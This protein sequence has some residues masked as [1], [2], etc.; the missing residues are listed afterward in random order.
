MSRTLSDLQDIFD[1]FKEE[2]RQAEL[3]TGS[4]RVS[5]ANVLAGK[6]RYLEASCEELESLL[7]GPVTDLQSLWICFLH[8]VSCM[9]RL[10]RGATC[11]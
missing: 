8:A 1:Y 5:L 10:S 3:A 9:K 4:K 6:R 2:I 11:D 7:L